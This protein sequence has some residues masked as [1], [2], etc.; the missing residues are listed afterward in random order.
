LTA[1]ESV[2]WRNPSSTVEARGGEVACPGHRDRSA[3]CK[4]AGSYPG[5]YYDQKNPDKAKK[6]LEQAG[7]KG[8]EIVLQTSANYPSFRDAILALSEEMKAA[9]MNVKVD[10]VDWTTNASN[11][12]RGTGKWNVS[13]TG[14][15]R[16]RCS[17][18]SSGE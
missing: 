8:D 16:T 3:I 17:A 7:Y 12:Q 5:A 14:F 11:M 15:A 13:T 18:L 1:Q 9:G 6:L 10:V 2:K 4:Q